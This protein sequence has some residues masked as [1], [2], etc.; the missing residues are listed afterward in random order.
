MTVKDLL[1]TISPDFCVLMCGLPASGKSTLAGLISKTHGH[2]IISTDMLR[3]RI[4][5]ER[6]I[7][8]PG[9]A[10]DMSKRYLVYELMFSEALKN[11]EEGSRVILDGTFIKQSLRKEAIKN[12]KHLCK[13]FALLNVITDEKIALKRIELRKFKDYESNAMTAEAY[14]NNLKEWEDIDIGDIRMY[15]EDLDIKVY[16]V[17][18]S[19][20]DP[21]TWTVLEVS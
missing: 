10:K 15:F 17:K 3:K 1:K 14:F 7:F 8:D 11:L 21:M 13:K 2:V 4:Y 16:Q 19:N 18:S 6:E 5:N 20:D 9:K 12:L